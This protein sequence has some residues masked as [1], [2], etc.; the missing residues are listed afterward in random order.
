V[1]PKGQMDADTALFE[2]MKVFLSL[3]CFYTPSAARET[4]AQSGFLSCSGQSK[5]LQQDK[6]L[7]V[8]YPRLILCSIKSYIQV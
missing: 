1:L 6:E 2:V 7:Q 3:G 8:C 5:H 4:E